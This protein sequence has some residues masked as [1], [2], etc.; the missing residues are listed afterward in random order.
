M[1]FEQAKSYIIYILKISYIFLKIICYILNCLIIG[2]L[3]VRW[4]KCY[5][6]KP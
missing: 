2:H 3:K 4:V 5:M 6:A 1:T